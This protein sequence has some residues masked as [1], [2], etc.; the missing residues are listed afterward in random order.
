MHPD[1]VGFRI[2]YADSSVKSSS[3]G[4][5]AS[6]PSQEVQ[7]V[8]FYLAETYPIWIDTEWVTENY[9]EQFYSADYYWLDADGRPGA[10]NADE[11]PT[12]LPEGAIKTGSTMFEETGLAFWDLAAQAQTVRIA[13]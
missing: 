10:G 5:W 13:P 6:L 4:E 12:T 7:F 3:D 1:Y 11:V 9:V 8:T 2:W